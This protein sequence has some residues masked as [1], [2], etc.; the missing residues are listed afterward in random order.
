MGTAH[1]MQQQLS[2]YSQTQQDVLSY[3]TKA[4]ISDA[5]EPPNTNALLPLPFYYQLYQEL[6]AAM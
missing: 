3:F 4:L 1:V 5:Y 6:M 2:S